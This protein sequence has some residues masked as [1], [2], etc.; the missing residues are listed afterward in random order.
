MSNP[1]HGVT[2]ANGAALHD[3]RPAV[4]A[5][6]PKYRHLCPAQPRHAVYSQWPGPLTEGIL[7]PFSGEGDPAGAGLFPAKPAIG[8]GKV[9]YWVALAILAYAGSVGTGVLIARVSERLLSGG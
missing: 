7:P 5:A 1:A 4:S 6:A 3:Q 8:P 2:S 9:L